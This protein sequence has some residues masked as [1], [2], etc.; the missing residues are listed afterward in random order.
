MRCLLPLAA[1]AALAGCAGD[2]GLSRDDY[3]AQATAI[4]EE[5]GKR[6]DEFR[7]PGVLELFEDY[8]D[9]VLPVARSQRD[10]VGELEPPADARDAHER[11][12]ERWSEVIGILEEGRES[13]RAGSDVGIVIT[14]RRATAAERAAD[15]AARE[16]GL[17]ACTGFNPFT[18]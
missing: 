12:V 2:E 1:A 18:R 16:L 14:L 8:F 15:E 5:H 13:A 17:G 3:T 7:R 9:D 10:A 11:L 6:I 4:C